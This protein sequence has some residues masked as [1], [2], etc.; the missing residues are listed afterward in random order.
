MNNA[1]NISVVFAILEQATAEDCATVTKLMTANITLSFRVALYNNCL[2]T[3]EA[4]NMALKKGKKTQGIN[5]HPQEVR[6]PRRRQRHKTQER[7][8]IT[9]MKK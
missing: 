7:K 2:S 4:D 8:T 6:P 5:S 9:K 3:K 1:A